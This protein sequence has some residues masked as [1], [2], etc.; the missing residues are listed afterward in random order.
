MAQEDREETTFITTWGTFCYKVI[1]FGLKNVRTTYQRA[2]VALFHDMMHKE[3]EPHLQTP[4][5]KS[6]NKVESGVLGS[7]RK[8]QGILGIT[9]YPCPG[10]AK[11]TNDTLPNSARRIN[12]LCLGEARCLKEE[13]T[14]HILS[15]KKFTDYEQRYPTL[16][17]TC[18]ALV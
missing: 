12:G 16:Q 10:N 15:N 1:P 2:M 5:E 8:S 6:E 9:S 17:R 4:P 3:V 14:S 18:C 7:L 11:K 13:R